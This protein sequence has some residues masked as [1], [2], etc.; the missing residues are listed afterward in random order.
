MVNL[1][2]NPSYSVNLRIEL[3]NRSGTL[4]NVTNAI[5]SEGGSFGQISLIESTLKITQREIT[6]N[7]SSAEHAEKIVDAVKAL[8]EVKLISVSDRTFDLHKN[9]STSISNYVVGQ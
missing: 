4:A 6:V 5:A 1:T 7:A 2:P 9:N 8:E 3:P